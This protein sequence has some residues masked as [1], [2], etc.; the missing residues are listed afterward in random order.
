LCKESFEKG[1]MTKHLASCQEKNPVAA[2]KGG[3]VE[4]AT[5]LH[6][7]VEGQYQPEYWLH[8]DVPAQATLD[9]LDQFLRRI[10]LECCGHMSQ[11]KIGKTHYVVSSPF[12]GEDDEEEADDLFPE[13]AES[14]DKSMKAQIG[15]V[16]SPRMKFFHE[17]DFGTTSYLTL[18][19]AS[20]RD[21]TFGST[22]VRLLARNDPP[23]IP[24][25]L[26]GKP[27]TQ[28]C[29]VCLCEGGAWFCN[30]CARKH[31]CG[32]E[33]LLPVVNSPRVGMCGYTG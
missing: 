4:K 31:E 20:V 22:A 3:K 29:G 12:E 19:V 11:F 23:A 32:D 6:L 17:Y 9:V 13:F 24:C 25:E 30:R 27:A 1:A 10:W 28:V 2:P 5:V 16:L 15:K 33:M 21:D 14:G 8:L 18:K 26:C 7:V